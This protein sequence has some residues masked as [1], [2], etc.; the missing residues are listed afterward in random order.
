MEATIFE[1]G[2]LRISDN[3]AYFTDAGQEA[4]RHLAWFENQIEQS[5]EESENKSLPFDLPA[6]LWQFTP[7]E[8]TKGNGS[9]KEASGTFI[10][11]VAQN[12]YSSGEAGSEG[13]ADHTKLLEYANLVADLFDGY[14][15]ECSARPYMTNVERDHLNRPVMVDKI[16]F[17][18]SGI[19]RKPT[20][21]PDM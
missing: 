4:P 2:C 20:G 19:R 15:L 6:I 1:Q 16:T 21:V 14:K 17:E 13:V 3:S 8:Y 12:R 9:R 7:T 11:H 18:W 5:L 10:L